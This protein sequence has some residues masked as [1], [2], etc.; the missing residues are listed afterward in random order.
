MAQR[1]P[2]WADWVATLPSTVQRLTG[3]W[4]LR[5]DGPPAHGHCSLVLPVRTADG[6]AA[7]LKVGFPEQ[8]SEHEHL[9]L[10]R[11]GGHGAVRLLSAD[12]HS[13]AL[14]LERLQPADLSGVTD[15]QACAAVA[16]LYRQLHVPALPSL[17]NLSSFIERQTAELANLPRSAPIPHRLVEQAIALGTELAA[18][19]SVPDRVLHTDLHYGNVLAG[20]REPWLAIDPKPLNGDP[21]YELAPMLW[22]NL[23][24]V[25]LRVRRRLWTLLDATG[26]DEERA[27]SWVI[28]RMVHNA[29]WAV[30]DGSPADPSWLTTCI[31]VTK[32]VQD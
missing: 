10:R 16:V 32:A 12:P 20:E 5:A 8:D 28:V 13:R 27:R 3:Q 30:R 18:D 31:A 11:W 15:S 25:R 2:Q 29:M 23:D 14:L 17:R 26:F 22:N 1:G 6:T 4:E 24:D 21:H 7:M 9:A 19:R